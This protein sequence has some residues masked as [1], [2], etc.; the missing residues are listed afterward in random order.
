MAEKEEADKDLQQAIPFLR[1]AEDAVNS[2]KPRDIT[3][4]KTAKTAVD[5]TRVILDTVNLLL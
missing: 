5:T 2:I 3:E 1:K 4:L